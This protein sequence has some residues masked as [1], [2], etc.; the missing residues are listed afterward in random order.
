M[1]KCPVCDSKNL[2]YYPKGYK[3]SDKKEM[4]QCCKCDTEFTKTYEGVTTIIKRG[5]SV[6][7]G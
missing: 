2:L 1:I 4:Y 7:L 6:L 3:K 5:S